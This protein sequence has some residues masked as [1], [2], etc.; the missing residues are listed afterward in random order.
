MFP[1]TLNIV[2][3]SITVTVGNRKSTIFLSPT[4]K[5]RKQPALF[6][7]V[8][9]GTL[10]VP[11]QMRQRHG[12]CQ[13]HQYMDMVFY[14]T[15]AVQEAAITLNDAGDEAIHILSMVMENGH[16]TVLRVDDDMMK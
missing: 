1:L 10:D 3:D 15:D 16:L 11:Y 9:T 7:P 14:T 13:V 5:V 8:T 2:D 4:H 12:W 6:C